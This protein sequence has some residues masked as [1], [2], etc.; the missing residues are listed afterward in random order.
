MCFLQVIGYH[1]GFWFHTVGQ[2][3]G[4]PLSG[5]PWYCVR[6]DTRMNAVYVSRHYFA[7][8]KARNTFRRV[9]LDMGY[10]MKGYYGAEG[11]SS[12]SLVV[13]PLL[14]LKIPPL[15]EAWAHFAAS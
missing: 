8:D 14:R 1:K 4:V 11:G 13:N 12:N 7:E 3:K 2:R 6:K 15:T 10:T 5:G 9:P